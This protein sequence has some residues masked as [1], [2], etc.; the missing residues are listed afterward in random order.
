GVSA[1]HSR[2]SPKSESRTAVQG[3]T[4]GSGHGSATRQQTQTLTHGKTHAGE[5]GCWWDHF[6]AW[7]RVLGAHGA[8]QRSSKGRAIISGRTGP[9][10]DGLARR[11][12][13]PYG[14]QM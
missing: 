4:S 10:G 14:N 12:G 9:R 1:Q 13:L 2:A 7:G 6:R 5:R 11:P 8:L 3:G